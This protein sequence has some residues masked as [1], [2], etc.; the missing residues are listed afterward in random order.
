MNSLL[1][2]IQITIIVLCIVIIVLLLVWLTWVLN[3]KSSCT[4]MENLS[5]VEIGEFE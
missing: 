5:P 4:N 2:N 3:D 1:S